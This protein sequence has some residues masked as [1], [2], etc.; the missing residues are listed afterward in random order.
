VNEVELGWSVLKGGGRY[1]QYAH[2][3]IVQAK[4]LKTVVERGLNDLGIVL[5]A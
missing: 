4:L 1:L 2:I 3:K 5:T